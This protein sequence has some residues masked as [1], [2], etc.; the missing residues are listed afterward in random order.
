MDDRG[1]SHPPDTLTSTV[2]GRWGGEELTGFTSG[3]VGKPAGCPSVTVKKGTKT[4]TYVI[5]AG[6]TTLADHGTMD[7][8]VTISGIVYHLSFVWSKAKA[9]IPGKDGVDADM[10]DWVKEWNTGKTLINGN[11]VITP[12]LF[13]GTKNSDGTV[14]GIAIGSFTLNTKTS[15]GTIAAEAVN[16]IYGFRDGYKTFYVDNG[17][18]A[19]L[20]YGDQYVRYNATTGKVEF[21]SGVSLNWVGATYID[22]DGSEKPPVVLHRAIL[23]SLDRFMAYLIEETKGRFP[24]W[25]APTQVKVLPVSE[26]TLDYAKDV[27]AKLQAAGVRVVLD[28]S[29]E[30]IGYKIRQAQQVDRVPYM[31]VLGAKEVEANNISVRDRKGE[32]TTMELD[33]FVAQVVDE[34]K[35][36]V[37]NG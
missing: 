32:T 11:T 2:G 35:N 8:P 1:K 33:A 24:T 14:S 28:E 18:N 9:G 30:K 7:I 19:Q 5:T 31:L 3:A 20:G 12:K 6:T 4:L 22:K 13:A 34:I 15:S 10:L 26:K 21:G 25:L 16:G 17:G 27:T 37:N 29:N 23:G 36:R